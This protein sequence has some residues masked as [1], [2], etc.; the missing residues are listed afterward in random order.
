MKRLQPNGSWRDELDPNGGITSQLGFRPIIDGDEHLRVPDA[1][2][3]KW[4]TRPDEV[5]LKA[6]APQRAEERPRALAAEPHR[7]R[8]STP[9]R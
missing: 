8:G 7:L 4:S 1:S 6:E 9:P 2:T 3:G 5:E